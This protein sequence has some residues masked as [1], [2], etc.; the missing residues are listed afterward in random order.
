MKRKNKYERITDYI[1]YELSL[2]EKDWENFIETAR[3]HPCESCE[4]TLR[5]KKVRY[6]TY[7]EIAS[8][9]SVI[10]TTN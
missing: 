4:N 7:L 2:A 1:E 9:N 3:K 8:A 5:N 10:S 6:N